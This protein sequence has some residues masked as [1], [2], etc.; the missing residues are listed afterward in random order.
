MKL[1]RKALRNLIELFAGITDVDRVDSL[2]AVGETAVCYTKSNP[3]FAD[4]HSCNDLVIYQQTSV[5]T[6]NSNDLSI[7]VNLLL[8]AFGTQR[9]HSIRHYGSLVFRRKGD[10]SQR[11]MTKFFSI[12]RA[13]FLSAHI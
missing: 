5:C 9:R 8:W 1:A 3:L 10:R 2:R 6:S 7:E 4:Q 13:F 11:Y 12:S